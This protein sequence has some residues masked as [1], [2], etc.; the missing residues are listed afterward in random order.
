MVLREAQLGRLD[1]PS[2]IPTRTGQGMPTWDGRPTPDEFNQLVFEELSA[3]LG[4]MASYREAIKEARSGLLR[5]RATLREM[6]DLLRV[7]HRDARV[8]AN[9]HERPV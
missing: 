1:D 7:V 8:R 2:G 6:D 9:T 5:A 3:A 4:R